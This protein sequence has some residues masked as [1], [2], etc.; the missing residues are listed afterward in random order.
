MRLGGGGGGKGKEQGNKLMDVMDGWTLFLSRPPEVKARLRDPNG[1]R[2]PSVTNVKVYQQDSL[3]THNFITWQLL[4]QW[5]SKLG[6]RS[7]M[8]IFMVWCC[9]RSHDKVKGHL[10]SYVKVYLQDSCMTNNFATITPF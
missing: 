3:M 5:Q 8:G 9:R 1:V 4:L 10:R 7:T 6:D 2:R